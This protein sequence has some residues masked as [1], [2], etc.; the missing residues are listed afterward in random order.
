MKTVCQ[1]LKPT[2]EMGTMFKIKVYFENALCVK[3]CSLNKDNSSRLKNT[4]KVEKQFHD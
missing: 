1:R 4:L 2:L 3:D